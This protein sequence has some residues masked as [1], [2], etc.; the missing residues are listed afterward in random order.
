MDRYRPRIAFR[1]VA[2]HALADWQAADNQIMMGSRTIGGYSR[3][4]PRGRSF[5]GV[6]IV[7]WLLAPVCEQAVAAGGAT[8]AAVKHR[9]YLICGASQGT[10]GF[11]LPD[12]RGYWRGLDVDI[13][14]AVAAAIFGDRN[15]AQFV[16]LTGEQRLTALETGAIDMLPRTLTWTLSRDTR[17]DFTFPDFYDYVGLLVRKS[18]HIRDVTDLKGASVCVQTGSTTEISLADVSRQRH[19]ALRPVIFD[20]VPATRQA[21][22]FG[23]CDALMSDASAL[24]S[25]RATLAKDPSAFEIVPATDEIE[26]LTPAVRQGDDQWFDIVKWSFQAL[27]VAEQLGITRSNVD[28]MRGSKDPDVRRFLGIEPGTGKALSL[29]DAWAYHIIKQLGNYGEIYDRDVGKDSPLKIKRGY[30]RLVRDGGLMLP[31]PFE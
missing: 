3:R 24:A 26:A 18:D 2:G 28:S 12:S 6:A 21:F 19:L 23:R 8:L 13:C 17:V 14:R 20:N 31:L 15:K 7:L 22:F 30:N 25:V 1:R 4:W 10:A 11:G 16:P 27:L 29:D 9:G 5:A